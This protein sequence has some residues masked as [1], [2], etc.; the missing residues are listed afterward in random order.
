MKF[1]KMMIIKRYVIYPAILGFVSLK[2]MSMLYGTA[3]GDLLIN[4]GPLAIIEESTGLSM[5]FDVMKYYFVYAVGFAYGTMSILL[6][7]HK[8]RLGIVGLFLMVLKYWLSFVALAAI[9]MFWIPI[10]ILLGGI[11]FGVRKI[12]KRKA[13]VKRAAKVTANVNG[14]PL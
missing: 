14:I 2:I 12:M 8:M 6:P 9:A 3:F 11:F 4:S 1:L 10:E 5:P 13:L 7:L